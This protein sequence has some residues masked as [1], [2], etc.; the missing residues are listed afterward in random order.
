MLSPSPHPGPFNNNGS[1]ESLS[2]RIGSVS[3]IEGIGKGIDFLREVEERVKS[4]GG[5]DWERGL[6][7]GDGRWERGSGWEAARGVERGAR[8]KDDLI[9]V[10]VWSGLWVVVVVEGGGGG[11]KE[12]S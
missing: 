4:L 3:T 8:K 5:W 6:G 1:S 12:D 10:E 9:G 11:G 2:G 7:W